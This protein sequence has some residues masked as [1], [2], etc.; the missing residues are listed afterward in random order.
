MK[1]VTPKWPKPS[2]LSHLSQ[3][4]HTLLRANDAPSRP[5]FIHK[6]NA[7]GRT[8][9]FHCRDTPLAHHHL[10][11]RLRCDE[12]MVPRAPGAGPAWQVVML[13]PCPTSLF[14]IIRYN[15]K[16]SNNNEQNHSH[17]QHLA[18]GNHPAARDAAERHHAMHRKQKSDEPQPDGGDKE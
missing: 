17:P 7:Y 6:Q 5:K 18:D 13:H 4:C 11:R 8:D 15:N 3:N 1:I 9:P 2:K 12:Y 10:P 16:T 14:I